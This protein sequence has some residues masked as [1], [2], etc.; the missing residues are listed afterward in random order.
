MIEEDQITH[1]IYKFR[2]YIIWSRGE[3]KL[4]L[5]QLNIVKRSKFHT[6][7]SKKLLY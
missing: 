4:F 7:S 2:R 3:S 6:I 5:Y 1:E